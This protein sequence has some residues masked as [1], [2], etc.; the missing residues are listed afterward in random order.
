VLSDSL[1]AK[2]YLA[3]QQAGYSLYFPVVDFACRQDR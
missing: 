3:S 1:R 2:A